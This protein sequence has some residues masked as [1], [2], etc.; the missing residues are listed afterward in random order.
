MKNN[1][2]SATSIK[3]KFS[4]MVHKVLEPNYEMKRSERWR[5]RKPLTDKEKLE[6]FDEVMKV[7]NA[8]SEE[9][10]NCLYT[11]RQ[12]NIVRRL[13]LDRGYVSKKKTSKEQYESS[14]V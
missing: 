4:N 8:C 10:V 12:R 5:K 6:K 9:L 7:Y 3:C 1:I 14:H 2:S 11:R 13:R